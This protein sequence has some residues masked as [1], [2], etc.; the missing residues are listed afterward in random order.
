MTVTAITVTT[1]SMKKEIFLFS[2]SPKGLVRGRSKRKI[3]VG[4]E[5]AVEPTLVH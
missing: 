1:K 3:F 4:R 2:K 5:V